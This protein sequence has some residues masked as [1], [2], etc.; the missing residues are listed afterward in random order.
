MATHDYS[1]AN[2]SGASFRTDLNNALAAIQSNNSNASSPATTVAYQWWADTNAGVLKIRNSSNNAWIELFQLDGTLTLED[3][4]NSAP[5]LSFRSD[6]DTGVFRSGANTLDIATGGSVRATFSNSATTITGDLTIPD[7]IVHTGDSNTKIRFPSGDTISFELGGGG[8]KVRFNTG[9]VLFGTTSQRAGFFN[10]SSQFS[11]HFQI[12]GA[13]DSDD[14]GRTNSIIYNST[15]N[16][17]PVLIFGKTM[18]SSVGSTTVVTNGAQ[19]GMISFQGMIG[20]EFTMGASIAAVV[21][22][23]I[24]DDDLPTDLQFA[25]TSDGGSSAGEKM[26]LTESGRLG[27]GIT[28]PTKMLELKAGND[29]AGLRMTNTAPTT[30]NVFEILPSISGISNTGFCIRDHTD[31]SNR[32]VIDGSGLVGINTNTTTAHLN[33]EGNGNQ[34][35]RLKNTTGVIN[36]IIFQD[37]ASRQAEIIMNTGHLQFS[38]NSSGSVRYQLNEN[39]QGTH[40]YT[41]DCNPKEIYNWSNNKTGMSFR[42]ASTERGNIFFFDS[43]VQFN[44][45]SDYRL[46]EN[47]TS[48]SDGITRIKQLIPRKFNWIVDESNT[49]VDGFLA[50][51]VSSIVPEAING[52]KD[53]VA[54]QEDVDSG[55]SQAVGDP[56]HQMIDHSKLVPLLVA[57]VKELVAKVETLEAA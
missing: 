3:G 16:A 53:A 19:L 45:S 1:L 52:T 17:G 47:V 34:T 22:G 4:S 37:N 11:P 23:S 33:V 43:G 14:A 55:R 56:I 44:T 26:R 49:P 9:G 51:E 36:R 39:G 31:S 15:S 18:G 50:H 41:S 48:I 57:A 12:E 46:K 6:L 38:P 40:N 30:D 2:Q 20:S 28:N 8:E 54:T 21:N 5:A 27:I 32:L 35:L 29:R 25:T 10:T 7:T 13:G 24:G 42:S